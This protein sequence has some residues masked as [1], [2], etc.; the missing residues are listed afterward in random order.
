M[1]RISDDEDDAII[2]INCIYI[3]IETED[4]FNSNE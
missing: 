1:L 2:V 3:F 4:S